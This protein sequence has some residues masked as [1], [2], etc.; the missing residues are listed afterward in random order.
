M[1]LQPNLLDPNIFKI[2]QSIG[3]ILIILVCAFV[4]SRY[5]IKYI[6]EACANRPELVILTSISWCFIICGVADKVGTFQ[7][8]GCPDCG[9]SIAAYPYG[10]DVIS[11]LIGIRDFL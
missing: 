4:I 8:D 6:Y 7:R 5:V 2:V 11:K 1:G 10:A 9:M 3:I